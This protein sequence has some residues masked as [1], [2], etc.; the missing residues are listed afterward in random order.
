MSVHY[1]PN[2]G[3]EV[4]AR[5]CGQ[6]GAKYGKKDLDLKSLFQVVFETITNWE[7][8]MLVTL[9]VL[10]KEPGKIARAFIG[11]ERRKYYHPVKFLL[12]WA[13]VNLFI[14]LTLK[15]S[16]G[17]IDT[18]SSELEQRFNLFIQNYI[19]L[20]YAFSVPMMALG[21]FLVFRKLDPVF[22]NY[23]V[24][25]C[26]IVGAGLLINI[27]SYL[28]VAL[29]RDAEILRNIIG[30]LFPIVFASYFY[31]SYFKNALWKS[32][33]AGVL[34]AF[35]LFLASL[36]ILTTVYTIFQLIE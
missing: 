28:M 2:C 4:T 19:S 32:G 10:A 27:P 12:F 25:L 35:F 11:G 34:T 21:P 15:V 14:A 9:Q 20:I 33:V 31:H 30:P 18:N 3:G 16:F 23:N 17:E 24:M 8:K 13:S 22:V 1:C 6:C 26:Y 5:F 29:W 7:Q 36:I